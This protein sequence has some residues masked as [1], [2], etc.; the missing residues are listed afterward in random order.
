[1]TVL[2]WAIRIASGEGRAGIGLGEFGNLT[3]CIIMVQ[4]LS[5]TAPSARRWPVSGRWT[6]GS[7][8]A[9][10]DRDSLISYYSSRKFVSKAHHVLTWKRVARQRFYHVIPVVHINLKPPD[11]APDDHS[12]GILSGFWSSAL[13]NLAF[14]VSRGCSS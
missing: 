2:L 3:Y 6:S 1:M 10:L 7:C 9:F 5:V 4:W 13:I 11:Q 8:K 12:L 14:L